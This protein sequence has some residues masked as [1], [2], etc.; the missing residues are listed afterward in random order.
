MDSCVEATIFIYMF[1][2][3]NYLGELANTKDRYAVSVILALL[4]A[5]SPARNGTI[6]CEVTGIR[7]Y[8]GDLPQGGLEIPCKLTFR[9]ELKVVRKLKTLL[10]SKKEIGNENDPPSKKTKIDCIQSLAIIYSIQTCIL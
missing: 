6:Y 5:M 3:H 8:S 9:G 7:C 2:P 1:G 10:S 4:L